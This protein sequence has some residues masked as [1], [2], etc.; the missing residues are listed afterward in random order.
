[1]LSY[2]FFSNSQV[3]KKGKRKRD[4][5]A[6]ASFSGTKCTKDVNIITQIFGFY[7]SRILYADTTLDL[8]VLRSLTFKRLP[9]EELSISKP[10]AELFKSS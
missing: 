1:M 3:H 8:C 2:A 4:E 7:R 10:E 9:S 5:I 6:N